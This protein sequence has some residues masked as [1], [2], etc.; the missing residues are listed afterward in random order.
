[1]T[2]KDKYY[3]GK[4][5]PKN[6]KKYKGD[7]TGIIYRSGWELNFMNY[8]DKNSSVLEWSSE[9]IKIP[10]KSPVDGRFHRYFVDFYMR[11]IDRK[12]VIRNALVEIKPYKQS[13]EPVKKKRK[14]KAYINEVVTY[15][16]NQAKWSAAKDYCADR[17][18]EFLVFTEK[19]LGN[20]V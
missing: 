7:P 1:M 16:I 6:P 9:E 14:T 18:W 11:Y 20:L 13:I 5:S 12:G 15:G 3:Q 19:E 8:L 10:Y 4:F 17:K 2:K